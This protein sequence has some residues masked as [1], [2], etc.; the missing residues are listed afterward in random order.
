MGDDVEDLPVGQVHDIVAG[1]VRNLDLRAAVEGRPLA[2]SRMAALAAHLVEPP[3]I[4]DILCVVGNRI[5]QPA[6]R[7]RGMPLLV[8]LVGENAGNA[9]GKGDHENADGQQRQN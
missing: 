9:P 7:G 5:A 2:I 4:L 8:P 3:A 6:G 1:Q